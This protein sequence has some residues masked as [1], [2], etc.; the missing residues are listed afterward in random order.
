MNLLRH[1]R[2]SWTLRAGRPDVITPGKDR[3]VTVFGAVELT[4]GRWVYRLGRRC[5]ADFL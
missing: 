5:A 1:L 2:S 4:T 3:Q